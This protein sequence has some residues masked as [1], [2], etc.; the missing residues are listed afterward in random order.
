MNKFDCQNLTKVASDLS[1][2]HARVDLSLNTFEPA[3]GVRARE[4]ADEMLKPIEPLLKLG[5]YLYEYLVERL[6]SERELLERTHEITIGG[7][8]PKDVSARI[9]SVD[10]E[11][12]SDWLRDLSSVVGGDD[13]ASH[14]KKE[15]E[16]SI[17]GLTISELNLPDNSIFSVVC[18]RAKAL[19]LSL[20]PQDLGLYVILD[21]ELVVDKRGVYIASE[22][23]N[24]PFR[25]EFIM[26]PYISIH[27]VTVFPARV[28]TG[29]MLDGLDM[30]YFRIPKRSKGKQSE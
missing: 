7:L 26:N 8:E 24:G 6:G 19:G 9:L 2:L 1:K 23:M 3:D 22:P 11:I 15:E 4:A 13:F 20:C 21:R 27:G 30:F 16:V 5:S 12:D 10:K 14:I 28:G 17:I 18:D 29:Q 25:A